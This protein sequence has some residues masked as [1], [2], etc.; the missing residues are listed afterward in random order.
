[1]TL[2]FGHH[3]DVFITAVLMDTTTNKKKYITMS[4]GV[5][6]YI[7]TNVLFHIMASYK[8][9]WKARWILTPV[10]DFPRRFT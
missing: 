3:L 5:E 9:S 8:T 10:P 6:T 4:Y 7:K 2:G 1:M